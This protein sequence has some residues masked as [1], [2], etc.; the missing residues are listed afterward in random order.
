METVQIKQRI[1]SPINCTQKIV[2]DRHDQFRKCVQFPLLLVGG[3]GRVLAVGHPCHSQVFDKSR[4]ES[5]F[6]PKGVLSVLAKSWA[7]QGSIPAP[8]ATNV[9]QVSAPKSLLS[10][11]KSC[12]GNASWPRWQRVWGRVMP[13]LPKESCASVLEATQD[14]PMGWAHTGRGRSSGWGCILLVADFESCSERRLW[15]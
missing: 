11:R 4:A 3:S 6:H 2:D 15:F 1:K 7:F 10:G 13:P 12:H 9:F 8:V 14:V 5:S